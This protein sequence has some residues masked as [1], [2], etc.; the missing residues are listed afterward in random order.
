MLGQL[1]N[2]R[3]ASSLSGN[4]VY[5]YEVQNLRQNEET[6]KNSYQFRNSG[7]VYIKV[8]YNRMNEEMRRITRMGGTIV[9]IKPWN[10]S[11]E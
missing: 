5:V 6:D 9:S 3:T 10:E 1:A 11:A 7:S 4:R 2:S 8:P